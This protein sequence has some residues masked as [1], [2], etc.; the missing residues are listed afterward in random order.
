LHAACGGSRL[1]G[2]FRRAGLPGQGPL[3]RL[4]ALLRA[5]PETHLGLAEV[6]H[7]AAEIGLVETPVELAGHLETLADHGLVGG[8][9]ARIAEPVLDTAPKSQSDLVY[10]ETAQTIDLDVLP[11]TLLAIIRQALAER[12]DGVLILVRFRR[13]PAPADDRAT[14]AGAGGR[15]GV[16]C[17]PEHNHSDV[18]CC[19]RLIVEICAIGT[20]G[21]A[22]LLVSVRFQRTQ[23]YGTMT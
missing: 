23:F 2:K 19:R 17:T 13:D 16:T 4:L 6:L 12:A 9:P 22:A 11:E 7:M 20:A 1:S 10:E 8:C 18:E 14:R 5:A 3:V 15:R 21:G